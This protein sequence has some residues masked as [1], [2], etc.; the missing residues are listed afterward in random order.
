[1]YE[2]SIYALHIK[3]GF[4]SQ[5]YLHI[6]KRI[7]QTLHEHINA[8]RRNFQTKVK[9]TFTTPNAHFPNQ[10]K[11]VSGIKPSQD[12]FAVQTALCL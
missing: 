11:R 3:T 6:E 10:T 12:G 4:V 9:G 7:Q 1:M 2:Q 5:L 8:T